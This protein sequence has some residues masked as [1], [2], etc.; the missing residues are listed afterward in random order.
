MEFVETKICLDTDFIIDFLKN[1]QEAV[2]WIKDNEET[3]DL[4]TTA[5]TVFE[6]YYGEYKNKY[7]GNPEKL[8]LFIESLNILDI[9]KITAKEAGKIAAQL[10]K[11]GELLEFRDI[12]IAAAT[13]LNQYALKTNNKKHFERIKR[14]T[15]V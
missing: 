12:L 1:R 9:T 8:D 3:S 2:N 7:K 10:E 11:E 4:A 5:I 6:L 14:L 13:L 15:L